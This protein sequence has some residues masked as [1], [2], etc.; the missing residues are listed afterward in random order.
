[1]TQD[2]WGIYYLPPF[3]KLMLPLPLSHMSRS[4]DPLL[5]GGA[6]HCWGMGTMGKDSDV[7]CLASSFPEGWPSYISKTLAAVEAVLIIQPPSFLP[8]RQ[9]VPA[10]TTGP[11]QVASLPFCSCRPSSQARECM[12][13]ASY[14]F[15]SIQQM[16]Q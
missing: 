3:R 2:K 1:M 5:V 7:W 15:L 8:S 6:G 10:S 9:G 11:V 14:E 16:K 13:I 12:Y 4:S